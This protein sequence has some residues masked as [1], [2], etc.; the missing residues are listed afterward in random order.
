MEN[1]S[2]QNSIWNI[3]R[4]NWLY[5]GIYQKQYFLIQKLIP[6]VD[7]CNEKLFVSI[8]II[9][10]QSLDAE[11]LDEAAVEWRTSLNWN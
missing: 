6:V 8:Y 1:V 5:F 7:Y 4:D 2:R 9:Y 10:T 11:V 3:L